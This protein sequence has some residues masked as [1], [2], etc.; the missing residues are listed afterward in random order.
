MK[1]IDFVCLGVQFF[2][3]FALVFLFFYLKNSQI[4]DL[5]HFTNNSENKISKLLDNL[6]KHENMFAHTLEPKVLG[7]FFQPI[8][9]ALD[10]TLRKLY[11]C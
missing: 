6:L 10:Q 11:I 8:S 1:N 4:V 9:T 2:A 7:L 3:F 5:E